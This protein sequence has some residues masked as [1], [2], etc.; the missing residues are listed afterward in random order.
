IVETIIPHGTVPAQQGLI[1][2]VPG[3]IKYVRRLNLGPAESD[4]TFILSRCYCSMIEFHFTPELHLRDGRIIRHLADA[5]IFAGEHQARPGVD[6]RDEILH[7]IERAHTRE[8][9]HAAAHNFLRWLEE[10]DAIQ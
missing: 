5:L 7:K 8:E 2:L 10:I 3:M 1:P 6:Q 4:G 9:A